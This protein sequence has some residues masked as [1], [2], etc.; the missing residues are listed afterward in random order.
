MYAYAIVAAATPMH[1][2]PGLTAQT[3]TRRVVVRVEPVDICFLPVVLTSKPSPTKTFV[4]LGHSPESAKKFANYGRI[5]APLLRN[6]AGSFPSK[7]MLRKFRDNGFKV[8]CCMCNVFT[9]TEPP[10]CAAGDPPT[11]IRQSWCSH[12]ASSSEK[13]RK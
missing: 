11:Q 8:A 1:S 12:D 5:G 10:V 3:Q 13:S 7:Y 9:P 4:A 2:A 6:E